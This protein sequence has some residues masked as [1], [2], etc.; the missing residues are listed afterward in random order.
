SITRTPKKNHPPSPP[1]F[2]I[3]GH[4]LNLKKPVHRT[5]LALSRT[6]GPIISLSLGVRHLLV[7]SS[8][9]LAE[10]CFTR[11]D[12]VL[13][14]RPNFL[15][16]KYISYNYS[17]VSSAPYGDHWHNLRRITTTQIL[18]SHCLDMS[19]DIQREE[20]R[21]LLQKLGLN[22]LASGFVRVELKSTLTELTL[23]MMMRVMVGK[24]FG[25]TIFPADYLPVLRWIDWRG[26]EKRG[27]ELG[28]KM[29]RLLQ[30]LVD[31]HRN[32]E[33][34]EKSMIDH[35]LWLQA[36]QPEY[37]TDEIIKGFVQKARVEIDTQIGQ[38]RLVD[39]SDL[40]RLPYIHNIILETLRLHPPAPLLIPHYSSDDC[41]IGGYGVSRGTMVLINAW[42]IHRDPDQW[43]DPTS[44]KPERFESGDDKWNRLML[45][46][47][48]GRR[49]CPGAQLAH[50]IMG[51]AL[52]SLIQCFEWKRIGEEE[53]DMAE[54]AGLTMP[55]KKP[56]EASYKPREIMERI[57]SESSN[58]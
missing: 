30:G 44:F 28:K 35:L 23:N 18:S 48:L 49:A 4:L 3:V 45:P 1:S 20:V 21:R 46:F 15:L 36:S 27:S 51:F 58:P 50:K 43:S 56:L 16:G 42:A 37:Y 11:N 55:K 8:K 41:E 19:L 2:P 22:G 57:L 33:E 31:E 14:N 9:S 34:K 13:A 54:G 26:Y 10:E 39:E 32:K 12:T 52:A 47:G 17:T 24:R 7:I 40:S 29:D 38:D 6:H 25:M 5:L 53:V